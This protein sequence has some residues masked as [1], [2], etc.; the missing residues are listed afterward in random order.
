[1]NEDNECN[2]DSESIELERERNMYTNKYGWLKTFRN[3]IVHT[4]ENFINTRLFQAKIYSGHTKI[5][6]L[7]EILGCLV[8]YN[9]HKHRNLRHVK[10]L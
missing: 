7:Y 4:K 6:L 10:F 8:D 2:N 9:Y 5:E 3:K 1:M